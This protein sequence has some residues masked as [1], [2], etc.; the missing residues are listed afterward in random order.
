MR[1]ILLAGLMGL[2]LCTPATVKRS[3]RFLEKSKTAL[4]PC[5]L[6]RP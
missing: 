5:F 3:V 4:A 6:A 2:V 1:R